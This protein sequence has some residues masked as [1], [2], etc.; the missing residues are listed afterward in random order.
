[1]KLE[2]NGNAHGIVKEKVED[3][4]EAD[5]SP[6]YP[7]IWNQY[8]AT[9][10]VCIASYA[11][12]SSG[13]WVS[14][15]ILVLESDDS[16]VGKMS[17]PDIGWLET[18]PGYASIAGVFIFAA[19]MD[20]FGRKMSGYAS[21]F[22]TI[23]GW[24]ALLS[25]TSKN[26]LYVGRFLMGMSQI[27][28]AFL[29][30]IY[31]S[32][33]SYVSVRGTLMT[34][35]QFASH[36]GS[37]MGFLLGTVCSYRLFTAI[38]MIAPLLFP[39]FFF[40]IP[41]SPQ[42]LLLKGKVPEARKA[43]LWYRGGKSA[44]V[45][46]EIKNWSKVKKSDLTFKKVIKN[47]ASVKALTIFVFIAAFS[48][49]SGSAVI[50]GYASKIFQNADS[51]LD[52][53]TSAAIM[54][55][56]KFIASLIVIQIVERFGR[57]VLVLFSYCSITVCL[58]AITIYSAVQDLS[59]LDISH[60]GWIPIVVLST[61]VFTYTVG[62][63][64]V[65]E[66]IASEMLTPEIKGVAVVIVGIVTLIVTIGTLQAYSILVQYNSYVNFLI[67]SV[68]AFSAIIISWYI[69]PE[70]KGKTLAEIIDM[71]NGNVPYINKRNECTR[72]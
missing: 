25:A 71:L 67:E 28:M 64:T 38:N 2:R 54:A 39:V 55:S 45:D 72:L 7:G 48:P 19:V 18:L 46:E 8:Y 14:P 42:F 56:I 47:K 58:V 53:N 22:F 50:N 60:L 21:S 17:T 1:M 23:I 70:T 41:E 5:T 34:Y 12:G 33:I 32:E 10:A 63:G 4:V 44:M 16:P 13:S 65:G 59:D 36:T 24:F 15:M 35:S 3:P 43:L 26:Q 31:L 61:Y 29:G 51:V 20:R 62:V 11:L 66:V 49:L 69:V 57:R 6:Y 27:G 30:P 37:L 68:F 9:F 40:W 52:P